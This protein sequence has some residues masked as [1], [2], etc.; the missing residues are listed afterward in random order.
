MQYLQRTYE[1]RGR[2]LRWTK[3]AGVDACL[4]AKMSSARFIK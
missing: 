2:V 4:I 1:I 3:G